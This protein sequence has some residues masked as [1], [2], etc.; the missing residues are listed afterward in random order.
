[1][2]EEAKELFLLFSKVEFALKNS[3]F[4]AAD[5]RWNV[6]VDWER[7]KVH[8]LGYDIALNED[9]EDIVELKN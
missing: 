9:D 5:T 6:K 3:G 2:E 7:F 4:A 8:I 1:M